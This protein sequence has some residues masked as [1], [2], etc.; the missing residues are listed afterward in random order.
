M[1][2]LSSTATSLPLQLALRSPSSQRSV[3]SLPLQQA[4]LRSPSSQRSAC[5]KSSAGPRPQSAPRSLSSQRSSSGKTMWPRPQSAP[6]SSPSQRGSPGKST[7]LPRPQSG[8]PA[9]FALR[10]QNA[11]LASSALR[12]SSGGGLRPQSAPLSRGHRP[13][14]PPAAGKSAGVHNASPGWTWCLP[15]EKQQAWTATTSGTGG[16]NARTHLLKSSKL[17]EESYTHPTRYRFRY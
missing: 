16:S 3:A 4:A 15:L 2:S 11:L 12:S 1:E 9:S 8:L 10:P 17:M 7:L 6:R 13:K 14:S 5:S